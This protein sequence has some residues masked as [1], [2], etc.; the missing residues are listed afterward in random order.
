M[1]NENSSIW[2]QMGANLVTSALPDEHKA[3]MDML[4]RGVGR[5][6]QNR[7][8]AQQA[9]D[10]K[11]NELAAFQQ[12]SA[13]FGQ[14][15]GMIEDPDKAVQALMD[16]KNSV[17]VPFI[18]STSLKYANN[19]TIMN[20]AQQVFKMGPQLQDY[21]SGKQLGIDQQNADT[22][23]M[24]AE[25]QRQEAGTRA[26][27]LKRDMET[28]GPIDPNMAP[29]ELLK[30]IRNMPLQE[31]QF[32]DNSTLN[33]AAEAY[34][35]ARGSQ[36]DPQRK[37]QFGNFRN[38]IKTDNG[39]IE[40]DVDRA[41]AMI[42]G[43]AE[44]KARMIEFGRGV[45][46]IGLPAMLQK[47]PGQYDDIAPY[48]TH[49]VPEPPEIQMRGSVPDKVIA[50]VLMN[51]PSNQLGDIGETV[52]KYTEW[53]KQ[54]KDPIALGD[55][56]YST[57]ASAI[58][59]DGKVLFAG[60]TNQRLEFPEDSPNENRTKLQKL[61]RAHFDREITDKM[62]ANDK[63]S[64]NT[65]RKL[66]QIRDAAIDQFIDNVAAQHGITIR[67]PRSASGRTRTEVVVDK[68]SVLS[69]ALGGLF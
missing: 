6:L 27:A 28:E 23:R 62:V 40:G 57:M 58:R 5:I 59:S 16:Y 7:F 30:R 26:Q 43:N 67:A 46:K 54:Q 8:L 15:F 69:R 17:M 44:M 9:E 50:G 47:F 45:A 42:E 56:F 18:T 36:Y 39:I 4:G 63:T 68:P 61:L 35:D 65:R 49:Q 11:Q 55:R 14:E 1:A 32:V 66:G 41:R 21:I 37:T 53:I 48:F 64:G 10:F 29:S 33:S 38:S 2:F 24:Q 60:G 19:P 31:A 51:T 3:D 34:A 52:D 22:A 13:Q 20:T 12:A 25:A